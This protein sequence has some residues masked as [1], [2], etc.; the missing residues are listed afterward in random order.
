MKFVSFQVSA[1]VLP[2]SGVTTKHLTLVRLNNNTVVSC[3]HA[4]L[5]V[6]VI[7]I[8]IIIIINFI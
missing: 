6:P 4:V 2:I 7:I 8:I 5:H 3:K 1:D